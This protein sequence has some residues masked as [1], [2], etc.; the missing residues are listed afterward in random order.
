[1][2]RIITTGGEA[3]C[4]CCFDPVPCNVCGIPQAGEFPGVIQARI[5]DIRIPVIQGPPPRITPTPHS[6]Y[7]GLS[8]PMLGGFFS[9]PAFENYFL[10]DLEHFR[11][12]IG[13]SLL[14][15]SN[16]DEENLDGECTTAE[17]VSCFQ[18]Q[19]SESWKVRSI[20]SDLN[21]PSQEI[22]HLSLA[23]VSFGFDCGAVSAP[24]D[25]TWAVGINIVNFAR[26]SVSGRSGTGAK[27]CGVAEWSGLSYRSPFFSDSVPPEEL[28][29]FIASKIDGD[30]YRC[31]GDYDG[32]QGQEHWADVVIG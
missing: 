14:P 23:A 20:D 9:I 16:F 18:A 6:F 22:A 5:A 24:V 30:V 2:S 11:T 10:W 19:T 4:T 7:I 13:A 27:L 15:C 17:F 26:L 32:S 8:A 21:D 28:C 1:M 25:V 31:F 29:G 3:S 12:S